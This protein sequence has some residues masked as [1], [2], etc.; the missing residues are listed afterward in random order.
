MYVSSFL[1]LVAGDYNFQPDSSAYELV[2]NGALSQD[3]EEY[4]KP[5]A[6]D[7]EFDMLEKHKIT[8]MVSA[9]QMFNGKEPELTN[10][11]WVKPFNEALKDEPFSGCLDYLFLSPEHFEVVDV[12][13][14]PSLEESGGPFPTEKEPSDHLM[15]RATLKL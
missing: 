1:L 10:Y 14:L 5:P 9:Y 3:H 2:T 6:F 15:I 4:P 13:Q 11:S 8:R 7:S 12:R